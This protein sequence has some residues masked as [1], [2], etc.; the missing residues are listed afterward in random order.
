[1]KIYINYSDSNLLA[2]S[3]QYTSSTNVEAEL[4]D[5]TFSFDKLDG[6]KVFFDED[7]KLKVQFDEEK[8]NTYLEE[9]KK[10]EEEQK[11]AE[12]EDQN[13]KDLFSMFTVTY[14]QSDKEGYQYKVFK[15]GDITIKKEYV[16]S[17][18]TDLNDGSDYTKPITY[19]DG[20]SVVKGLWY[21]DGSDI[22]ECIKDGTPTGFDDK[23]YFDIVE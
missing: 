11:K 13:I 5:S 10:A 9:Q 23:E 17:D 2:V 6:Y 18:D 20:M 15:L 3:S 12:Q 1:M 16:K 7:G 4:V 21:T 22:W 8:Y 14:E 19:K